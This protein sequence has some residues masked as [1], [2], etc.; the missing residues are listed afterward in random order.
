MEQQGA[1][2]EL[3]D[4]L[5]PACATAVLVEPRDPTVREARAVAGWRLARWQLRY[6]REWTDALSS[7]EQTV[8]QDLRDSPDSPGL[9]LALGGLL[10]SLAEL[11]RDRGEAHA[12]LLDEA[13]RLFDSALAEQPRNL[14]LLVGSAMTWSARAYTVQE[15]A[16]REAFQRSAQRYRSALL[17][18]PAASTVRTSLG[19]LLSE[20]A[21]AE[22]VAGR[23]A[24]PWLAEALEQLEH[25]H[26]QRPEHLPLMV[27]LALAHWTAAEVAAAANVD[28]EPHFA[29]A[30][31][32]GEATLA[33]DPKRVYALLNL[34]GVLTAQ[35]EWQLARGQ[36]ARAP[37]LAARAAREGLRALAG[38]SF[39]IPCD[40][41]RLL[42][43]ESEAGL[44]PAAEGLD[45]AERHAREGV[46]RADMQDCDAMLAAVAER[47]LG[48]GLETDAQIEAR[49]EQLLEIA[50][51]EEARAR[52]GRYLLMAA[53]HFDAHPHAP[54]WK[55]HGQ[56]LLADALA[57]QP[58]LAWR[59]PPI[60]RPQSP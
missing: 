24:E 47:R 59:V 41:A 34:G 44:V 3:D 50:T 39:A 42:I 32:L 14:A 28:P 4:S 49:A 16:A 18:A 60:S 10:T 26:S 43:A 27:N 53:Q 5:H 25:A 20:L 36:D 29:R 1:A 7:F 58:H 45:L 33:R 57:S 46:A 13:G 9:S 48:V 15:Q 51:S 55:E 6:R 37:L 35:A 21:Y 2:A 52:V 38:D 8:R 56:R 22:F 11:R 54:L 40:W 23:S 19:G 31:A 17:L 30:V 12:E